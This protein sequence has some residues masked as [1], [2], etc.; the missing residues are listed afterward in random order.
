MG[1]DRLLLESLAR[2]HGSKAV[3]LG[4]GNTLKGDDAAGPLVCER[5]AGKVSAKVIDAG[6]TPENYIRPILE[7]TPDVLLMVDAVDLGGEPGQIHVCAPEQLHRFALSTHA[8]SLHLLI[9]MIRRE[10]ELD[11]Y[12]IGIQADRMR[13]GDSLSPAVQDAVETLVDT[14]IELFKPT[15]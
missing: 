1:A 14:L 11:V 13:F 6:S 7:T 9:D 3:I 4:I 5:L 12:L 2:W 10:R 15:E 8:L